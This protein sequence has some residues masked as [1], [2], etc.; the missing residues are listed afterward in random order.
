[1]TDQEDI[2]DAPREV[3]DDR[4]GDD[5]AKKGGGQEK[6]QEQQKEDTALETESKESVDSKAIQDVNEDINTT[7]VKRREEVMKIRIRDARKSRKLDLSGTTA[8]SYF[9]IE[10]DHVPS[11]VY[12]TF[13]EL[14]VISE[15][16]FL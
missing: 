10:L 13:S 3:D 16:Y 6:N 4:R 5:K 2:R 7:D 8:K 9:Q 12:Q 14:A 15:T 1:M 11:D